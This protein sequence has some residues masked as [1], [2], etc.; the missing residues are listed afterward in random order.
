MLTLQ[1]CTYRRDARHLVN[2]PKLTVSRGEIIQIQG[3]NGSGKTTLLKLIAGYLRPQSGS[4]LWQDTPIKQCWEMYCRL[5]QFVGHELAIKQQCSVNE[6]VAFMATLAQVNMP[7]AIDTILARLGLEAYQHVQC[8][9]LSAGLQKRV[10][11]ARLFVQLHPLWLLDEPFS[12]LD[13]AGQTI[14]QELM[15]NHQQAGG[16]IIFTSHQP[17]AMIKSN[18]LAMQPGCATDA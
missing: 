17:V 3:G 18:V 6:N 1:N 13:Q 4:I 16:L 12:H 5:R 10:S 7:I 11:L 9:Q 8:Q 2:I 14:V 15:L